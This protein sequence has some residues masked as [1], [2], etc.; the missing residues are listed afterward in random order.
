MT[1]PSG[2]RYDTGRCVTIGVD[3]VNEIYRVRSDREI[4]AKIHK[5]FATSS[6]MGNLGQESLI[7]ASQKVMYERI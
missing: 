1:I 5:K 4:R 3:S 7:S 2:R 6:Y